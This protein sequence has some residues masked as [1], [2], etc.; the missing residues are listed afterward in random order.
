[1][2][3][4]LRRLTMFKVISWNI[5]GLNSLEKQREVVNLLKTEKPNVCIL[6][7]TKVKVGNVNDILQQKFGG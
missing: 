2:R 7:E 6:V 5:R 3:K 1:M 4:I